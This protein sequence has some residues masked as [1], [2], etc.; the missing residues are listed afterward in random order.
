MMRSHTVTTVTLALG[1]L[2]AGV[3]GGETPAPSCVDGHLEA[4]VTLRYDERTLGDVAGLFLQVAYPEGV[5][6]PGKGTD[7]SVRGRIT[8]LLDAKFRV[9]SVDEDSDANGRE[10]R[11]RMLLVATT[12][13]SLP[14]API[15][16]IRFDCETPQ[17]AEAF[18]CTTDQVADSAGQLLREKEAKQVT[19]AVSFPPASAPPAGAR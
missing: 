1:M 16:R 7:E 17:K 2:A 12:K 5:S 6:V 9:V 10:D 11:L 19:C 18:R 14:A 4:T 13:D 15:A 8:S 3:A